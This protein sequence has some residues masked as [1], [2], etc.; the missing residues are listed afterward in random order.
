M[1]DSLQ[2]PVARKEGLVIQEMPDEVLVYDL[3]TNK[4]HCLNKTAAFV[5]NACDGKNSVAEI[6]K[7]FGNQSGKPVASLVAPPAAMAVACSGMTGSCSRGGAG[8]NETCND[9][10]P[11]S[12]CMSGTCECCSGVCQD[13]ASACGSSGGAC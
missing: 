3:E 4:A 12:G 9:C 10:T 7:L 5:W 1:N 8:G 6:T 11:C 13:A 2:K